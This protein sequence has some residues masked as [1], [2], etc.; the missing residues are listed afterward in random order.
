MLVNSISLFPH[1]HAAAIMMF[2]EAPAGPLGAF[3]GAAAAAAQMN[4]AGDGFGYGGGR[5]SGAGN[6]ARIKANGIPKRFTDAQLRALFSFCGTVRFAMMG[7]SARRRAAAAAAKRGAWG[8]R[9]KANAS[10]PTR[11]RTRAHQ[12]PNPRTQGRRGAH[13]PRQGHR[14]ARGL[15]VRQLCDQGGGRC[16]NRAR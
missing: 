15:R 11:D 16:A 1:T 8:R 12:K 5:G 9:P 13:R 7:F 2:A 3:G 14:P 10:F 6:P 4:G